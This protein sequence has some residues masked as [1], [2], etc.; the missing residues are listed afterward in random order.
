[1]VSVY[2]DTNKW[3]DLARA[4]QG[5]PASKNHV[6]V[7]DYLIDKAQLRHIRL[8]LTL[9]HCYEMIKRGDPESRGRLWR[10]AVS[11]SQCTAMLNKQCIQANL[12][13]EAAWRVFEVPFARLPC[14]PFTNSGLFGLP[15]DSRFPLTDALLGTPDGWER[16]WLK[17][18]ESTRDQLFS[19]LGDMERS[20]VER[21][22]LLKLSWRD[23]DGSTRRRAYVGKIILDLQQLYVSALDRIGKSK[24]DIESLTM[25]NRIRLVTDVPPFDVEVA[26]GTE[27][28]QQWD[29]PE[30]PNDVRDISH[31]CMAV[32]YC[33]VVVTERYWIDKLTRANLATKYN[34][35]V[36]HDVC[37]LPAV[38]STLIA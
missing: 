16:F 18:P 4:H 24:A 2:L 8:P 36:L 38:L 5:N 6:H 26:L 33:D 35:R 21:R 34:T 9:I 13:E 7:L 31:L 19:G 14:D 10:F 3:I 1:M 25:E 27:H 30:Q 28:Q 11:L 23:T 22:N 20:F 37:D 12:I 32:P 15:F 17:L 29:K